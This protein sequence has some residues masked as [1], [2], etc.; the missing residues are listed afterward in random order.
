MST[1]CTLRRP[2]PCAR[3]CTHLQG[4]SACVGAVSFSEW[5]HSVPVLNLKEAEPWLC[6]KTSAKSRAQQDDGVA[7]SGWFLPALSCRLEQHDCRDAVDL[8]AV[9]LTD[10]PAGTVESTAKALSAWQPRASLLLR[11][12]GNTWAT[13]PPHTL[14]TAGLCGGAI[15][16]RPGPARP[17]FLPR[18]LPRP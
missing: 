5:C 11:R 1:W 4:A 14:G 8:E 9:P 16:T 15:I 10:R 18:R 7:R 12:Q 3:P 2:W 13:I 17:A 6:R